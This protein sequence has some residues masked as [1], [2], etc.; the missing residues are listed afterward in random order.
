[1]YNIYE[2][3]DYTDIIRHIV[4][5]LEK[6][7]NTVFP[8]L[9]QINYWENK[10]FMHQK[11]DEVGIKTPQSYM[12]NSLEELN[13]NEISFPFLIKEPHSTSA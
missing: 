8:K 5:Q 3:E 1:M 4:S 2:F 13:C 11:F 10:V 12:I 7:D 9:E 6:Q